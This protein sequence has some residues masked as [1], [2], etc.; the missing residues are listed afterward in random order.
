MVKRIA[1][2]I[3]DHSQPPLVEKMRTP[4]FVGADAGK[5]KGHDEKTHHAEHGSGAGCRSQ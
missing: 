4:S 1:P 5:F 3:A 2:L